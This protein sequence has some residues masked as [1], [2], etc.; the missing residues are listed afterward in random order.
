MEI[1][2]A[3]AQGLRGLQMHT[4]HVIYG[5]AHSAIGIHISNKMM[6][7]DVEIHSLQNPLTSWINMLKCTRLIFTQNPALYYR[8]AMTPA[9][10]PPPPPPRDSSSH[11]S[12]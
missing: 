5:A 3:S 2:N 10:W 1:M 7:R 4:G 8:D 12:R 11:R 6:E 9:Q